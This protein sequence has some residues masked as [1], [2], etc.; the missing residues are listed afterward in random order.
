MSSAC[1]EAAIRAGNL[2]GVRQRAAAFVRRWVVLY[3]P[4]KAAHLAVLKGRRAFWL[5]QRPSQ[6][7][8]YLASHRLRKLNLG[9]GTNLLEGWINTDLFPRNSPR[10]VL[11]DAT[12]SLPFPDNSFDYV[13]TEHMIEHLTFAQGLALLRECYRILKPGAKIRIATPD[14]RMLF[15]LCH[16]PRTDLQER[17]IRWSVENF[18]P[19]AATHHEAFV[20]NNFFRNWGHQFIYDEATLRASLERA[21]FVDVLRCAPGE[22]EDEHLHGI[23]SHGRTLGSEDMNRLETMALEARHPV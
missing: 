15:D 2:V 19:G 17:Y 8:K 22:S 21:G 14:L 7:K 1:Y 9:S 11:L 18:I 16:E 10:P 6:I 3:Y 5:M 13:F 12:E 20:I 4:A 23:E